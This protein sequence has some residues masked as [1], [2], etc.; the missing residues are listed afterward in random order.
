VLPLDSTK[1]QILSRLVDVKCQ[2]TYV[3][4]LRPC[5]KDGII[6]SNEGTCASGVCLCNDTR[7]GV[8]CESVKTDDLSTGA[9]IGIVVGVVVPV[10]VVLLILLILAILILLCWRNRRVRSPSDIFLISSEAHQ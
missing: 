4:V 8:Y 1:Q 5:V 9:I 10:I 2:E 7:T 3:N 6:C